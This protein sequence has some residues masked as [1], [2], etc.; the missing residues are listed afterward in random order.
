MYAH[1]KCE[2]VMGYT[3]SEFYSEDFDFLTL[4]APGDR[5]LARASFHVHISSKKLELCAYSLS[6]RDG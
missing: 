5:E 1:R 4:V 2:E 6:T 3:R